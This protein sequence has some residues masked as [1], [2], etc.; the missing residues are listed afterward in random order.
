MRGIQRV[1]HVMRSPVGGLFRHVR[2]LATEQAAA[3]L[4]VGLICDSTTGSQ[5]ADILLAELHSSCALG[6]HRMPM[7]RLPGLG[8][9]MNLNRVSTIASQSRAQILHGHGAK[10]GLYARIA[11]RRCSAK[12][13]YTPH[14]GSLHYNWLSATGWI[15]LGMEW[16][17][18]RLGDGNIFVCE[19]EKSLYARKIGL[20]SSKSTVVHNGLRQIDFQP[21][22]P[23]PDASDLLFVGELRA[24]K[25]VDLL[26]QAL[27]MTPGMTLALVGS[28]PEASRFKEIAKSLQ[29]EDRARFLGQMPMQQALGEGRTLIVPSRNES[30][31]YVV[32]EAAA[33][34]R[35]VLASAVGGIPEILPAKLLFEP[36]S[37]T[38]IAQKLAEL[39][40]KINEFNTLVEVTRTALQTRNSTAHMAATVND[41]Y[42]TL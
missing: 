42:E 16:V 28:G 18:A 40:E 37:A 38:A 1:L 39:S 19:F 2:D 41:F 5:Q 3:G 9:V 27:S 34:G 24:L 20:P 31:P 35:I 4:Q 13:V 21:V 7:P 32:L 10:G 11:A 22:T 6:I 12:S 8:D 26:L 25:G 15:F 17:L 23:K 30:Y 14:G 36:R 29:V 33:S